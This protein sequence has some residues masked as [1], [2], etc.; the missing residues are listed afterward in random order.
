MDRDVRGVLIFMC[1]LFGGI[2]F[3]M[4]IEQHQKNNCRIEAM[5]EHMPV[6][7]IIKVCGK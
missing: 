6:D 2:F 3:V 5:K 1:V 4:G 7:D